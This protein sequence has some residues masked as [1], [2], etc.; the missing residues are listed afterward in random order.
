LISTEAD[1][2]E[3]VLARLE[4]GL[5][6][7]ELSVDG[8]DDG[9]DFLAEGVVDSF[10]LVELI[11]AVE[12]HFG[13]SLD[14]EDVDADEM[15]MLGPFCRYVAEHTASASRTGSLPGPPAELVTEAPGAAADAF[16][17]PTSPA[18]RRSGAVRRVAGRATALGHRS[19]VRLRDKLFSLGYAG[20]FH[21]FGAH[22]V[23]QMP[24]RIDHPERMSIGG[25]GFIGGGSWLH[26]LPGHGDGVAIEIGDGISVT[27]SCVLSAVSS[28]RIGKDVS[29]ARNV[30]ISDHTHVY[31]EAGV[32]VLAQGI[33]DPKPVEIGD[34]AWL[35]E[36]VMVFPGV[37]IGR[38][39]VV[40]GN[41][42]VSADIPDYSLALG[43]PA[44]VVRRLDPPADA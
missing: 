16:T 44:R 34:G 32:P 22:T 24:A 39:A 21:S 19:G 6:S 4:P 41:S 28:I 14:F 43:A 30:Y 17:P 40:G 37:R 13:V 38:G 1:V 25:G 5:S 26:V 33:T 20:S 9:F 29:F 12:Q 10:G 8:L 3:V 42:I 15:T 35:G 23:I 11:G 7:S 31:D 2:R 18:H 27:G 36:N